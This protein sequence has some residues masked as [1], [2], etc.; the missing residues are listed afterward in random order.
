MLDD[1]EFQTLQKKSNKFIPDHVLV[2]G[3]ISLQMLR[4][5]FERV[6]KWC[7]SGRLRVRTQSTFLVGTV[8]VSGL[9]WWCQRMRGGVNMLG[10]ATAIGEVGGDFCVF[11]HAVLNCLSGFSQDA[12]TPL[13]GVSRENNNVLDDSNMSYMIPTSC[14]ELRQ[15]AADETITNLLYLYNIM[16]HVVY[17]LII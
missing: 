17:Q 5:K 4:G 8:G 14:I 7:D 16:M 10:S 2:S 13:S 1:L 15:A 9:G 12:G 11:I 3:S 6:G